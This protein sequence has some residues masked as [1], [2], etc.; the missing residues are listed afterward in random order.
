V[1]SL[2]DHVGEPVEFLAGGETF[3]PADVV[4]RGGHGG[5]VGDAGDDAGAG[6]GAAG[7]VLVRVQVV[8]RI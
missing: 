1:L 6:V 7:D 3:R 5:A 8:D 4:E 2:A